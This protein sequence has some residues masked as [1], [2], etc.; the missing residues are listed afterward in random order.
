MV[1]PRNKPLKTDTDRPGLGGDWSSLVVAPAR[2]LVTG[3]GRAGW[4]GDWS[5]CAV[6]LVRPCWWLG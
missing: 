3:A 5:F 6:A 2:G 1:V 4:G